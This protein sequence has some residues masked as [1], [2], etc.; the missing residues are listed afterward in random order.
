MFISLRVESKNV[1]EII[2]N[3]VPHLFFY[4]FSYFFGTNIPDFFFVDVN[5]Q[6]AAIFLLEIHN[7]GYGQT[8]E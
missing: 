8:I 2:H 5:Q 6:F 7:I 1:K 4:L 3:I